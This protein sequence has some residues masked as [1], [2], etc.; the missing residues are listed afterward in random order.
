MKRHLQA[1]LVVLAWPCN[2]H[3]PGDDE[4]FAADG[5]RVDLGLVW[6]WAERLPDRL[7][8]VLDR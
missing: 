7:H 6:R 1:I 3:H 5:V 4:C 2:W 8:G